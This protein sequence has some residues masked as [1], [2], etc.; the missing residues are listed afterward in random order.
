MMLNLEENFNNDE[1]CPVCGERL[2]MVSELIGEYWGAPAYETYITC[3]N[4]CE[5]EDE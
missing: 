4:G 5:E 3:P 2:R 1:Y